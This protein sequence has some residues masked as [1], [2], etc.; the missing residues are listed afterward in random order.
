[1]NLKRLIPAAILLILGIGA[2]VLGSLFKIQH[3]TYGSEIL[4]FGTLLEL[5][6]IVIAIGTLLKMYKK[7]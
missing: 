3:W 5:L 6:A 1:M 2:T 4:M 7:A